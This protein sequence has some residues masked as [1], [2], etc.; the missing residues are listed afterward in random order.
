M[1]VRATIAASRAVIRTVNTPKRLSKVADTPIHHTA[2]VHSTANL[3]STLHRIQARYL[4]TA[5]GIESGL[6]KT[7]F[8]LKATDTSSIETIIRE[9][10]S[11]GSV[12]GIL[13][14]LEG[15]PEIAIPLAGRSRKQT[16]VIYETLREISSNPQV[17]LVVS[18]EGMP[19]IP[20]ILIAQK[21]HPTAGEK[22]LES[23]I[24]MV[25]SSLP[26]STIE[27]DI[28]LPLTEAERALI[29]TPET[30]LLQAGIELAGFEENLYESAKR[31]ESLQALLTEAGFNVTPYIKASQPETHPEPEIINK[32]VSKKRKE[33]ENL[34]LHGGQVET[35]DL[36]E[37]V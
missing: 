16:L 15:N 21:L 26:K 35:T 8:K 22:T 31:M 34:L 11:K 19:S 27:R 9:F 28:T 1:F 10:K 23:I 18:R 29:P 5:T 7:T 6:D 4:S 37:R 14:L 13:E 12:E 32:L 20:S 36:A 25:A 17:L 24:K 30:P 2:P 3:S 33:I